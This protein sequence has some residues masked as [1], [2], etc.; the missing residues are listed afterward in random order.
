MYSPAGLPLTSGSFNVHFLYRTQLNVR[1]FGSGGQNVSLAE[2]Q[3][4]GLN[5]LVSVSVV[6]CRFWSQIKSNVNATK[7]SELTIYTPTYRNG[8]ITRAMLC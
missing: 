3:N 6:V 2:S 7:T 1:T 8:F 5:G 4:I